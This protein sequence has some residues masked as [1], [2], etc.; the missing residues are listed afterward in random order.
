M[1]GTAVLNDVNLQ[2]FVTWETMSL[3]SEDSGAEFV[4]LSRQLKK[5]KYTV[6]LK[7]T[8]KIACY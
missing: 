3:N 2:A 8:I 6:F 7:R 4:D 5:M 1:Y